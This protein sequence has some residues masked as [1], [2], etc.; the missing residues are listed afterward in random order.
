MTSIESLIINR[1]VDIKI[2]YAMELTVEELI[3]QL[4]E[5]KDSH[6]KVFVEQNDESLITPVIGVD[7]KHYGVIIK[8]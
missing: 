6:K 8:C 1:I 7:E 3:E 5:I 4:Q 2:E